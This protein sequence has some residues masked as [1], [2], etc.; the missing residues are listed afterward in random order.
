MIR[1]PPRSTLFPY[2]TLF[3][4]QPESSDRSYQQALSAYVERGGEALMARAYDFGRGALAPGRS[5]HALVGL[6]S[7]ALRGLVAAAER[8]PGPADLLVSAT[9]LCDASKPPFTS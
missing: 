1:R 3:R 6:P 5:I 7:R 2:T 8:G 4:S 9:A